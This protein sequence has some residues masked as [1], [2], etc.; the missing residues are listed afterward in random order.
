M[1]KIYLNEKVNT[2]FKPFATVAN[3]GYSNNAE[4]KEE[5]VTLQNDTYTNSGKKKNRINALITMSTT[6]TLAAIAFIALATGN[7]QKISQ[8]IQNIFGGVESRFSTVKDKHLHKILTAGFGLF[9]RFGKVVTNSSPIKDYTLYLALGKTNKTRNFRDYISR[10]F[11]K[12]N[13]NSVLKSLKKSRESYSEFIISLEN[14][15][16]QSEANP[17]L[18]KNKQ[19]FS[20]IKEIMENA[21]NTPNF[22]SEHH[23]EEIYSV[24]QNDMT[25]LS[26]EMS[27]KRFLSKEAFQGFLP[28]LILLKRR[29]SYVKKL[30]S[31]KKNI[32]H[33]FSDMGTYAK[34]RLDD[35][36]ILIYSIK[37]SKLQLKLKESSLSFNKNL[38][39]YVKESPDRNTRNTNL[40]LVQ[41]SIADLKKEIDLLAHSDVK[42]KLLLHIDEYENLFKEHNSGV[43]EDIRILAGDAWGDK[44][45]FDMNI[46]KSAMQHSKDLNVSLDRMINMFDKERDIT[47]GSGPAD[48]LGMLSPIALF[49]LALH[50]ADSKEEKVGVSLE[51]GVPLVGGFI[52]YLRALA[53]QYNGMKALTTSLGTGVLL[54]YAGS[55]IYKQYIANQEKLALKKEKESTPQ[56]L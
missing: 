39:K 1:N 49:A 31:S 7:S 43:V 35:V 53:L 40:A 6:A 19:K 27:L 5:K 21:R 54:N 25:F 28:E 50:K 46:K 52:V 18:I 3:S 8:K 33:S 22:L 44:S 36:N 20:R 34:K 12:E 41:Q 42:E 24:M 55:L 56:Q 51:L 2:T 23:F 15:I 47:L 11:T 30:L 38:K 26:H 48:V 17:D 4:K 14:A 13:R 32:S 16:K 10:I 9:E 37:D 45:Q 29:A